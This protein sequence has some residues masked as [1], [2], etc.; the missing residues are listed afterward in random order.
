MP[1]SQVD[2]YLALEAPKLDANAHGWTRLGDLRRILSLVR[3][4][5][6]SVVGREV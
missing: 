5:P 4:D 1:L 6:L 2:A 3:I